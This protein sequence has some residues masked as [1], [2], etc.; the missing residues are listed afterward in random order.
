MSPTHPFQPASRRR[1]RRAGQGACLLAA[2]GLLAAPAAALA[3]PR[4]ANEAEQSV[5]EVEALKS[6]L[7]V[8][9]ITC[10]QEERYNDF[11][12]RYQPRLA[13]NYRAFEQ[14]F[15]R[16]RGRAGKT[17]TDAYVTN[18]AQT[19]G[20]EAQKLG[21]DFCP[22]NTGLFDEVMALPSAAE[23]PAYAA[24]KDLIPESLGACQTTAA[25]TR[26]ASTSKR[27]RGR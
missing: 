3:A 19:R 9:G 15:N 10:Q 14:H 21:S 22:R 16:A 6:E 1:S 7:M 27:G 5:F 12:R 8:V 25:P 24:G 11:V 18:L 20:F 2:L 26:T 4:C 23:L 17:A 13:E